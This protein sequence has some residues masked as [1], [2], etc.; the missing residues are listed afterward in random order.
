MVKYDNESLEKST[1][2]VLPLFEDSEKRRGRV[3]HR[4]RG[5]TCADS[6]DV[7]E[8]LMDWFSGELLQLV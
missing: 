8:Q 6:T 1:D 2:I 5:H 4:F 3:A 7:V